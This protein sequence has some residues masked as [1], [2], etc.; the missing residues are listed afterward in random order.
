[1]KTGLG[2]FLLALYQGNE[3]SLG[4]GQMC[5]LV[6]FDLGFTTEAYAAGTDIAASESS[7]AMLWRCMRRWKANVPMSA[8]IQDD[9]LRRIE[10]W[11]AIRTEA[12]VGGGKRNYY[13][14]CAAFIAAYGEVLESM[15]QPGKKLA[16][17]QDY[18]MKYPRHTAFRQE[19]AAFGL[20]VK[21]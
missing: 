3:L 5:S 8:E 15:G 19:L 18:R 6:R 10:K 4:T 20:P 11:I 12:I 17:M 1:M 14:E 7:E 16:V 13:R 9:I 2:L 21:K